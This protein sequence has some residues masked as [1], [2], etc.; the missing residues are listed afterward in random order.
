MTGTA[1][2]LQ[3]LEQ[4]LGGAVPPGLA[5]LESGDLHDLAAAVA[6]ARRRQAAEI[7]AAGD[8]ALNH[9][10]RILRIA[11]RKVMG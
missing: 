2:G 1:N 7:A 6:E 4:E 11:I 3:A 10:P 9:V 5:G 8:Q